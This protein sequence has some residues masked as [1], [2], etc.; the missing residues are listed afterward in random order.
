MKGVCCKC[1]ADEAVTIGETC[2]D[3]EDF[4][5][6]KCE[7]EIHVFIQASDEKE[8]ALCIHCAYSRAQIKKSELKTLYDAYVQ[9]RK[10][11]YVASTVNK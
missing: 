5:C 9:R 8:E 10:E 6:D 7:A 3:C 2:V 1:F 4:Y 11:L